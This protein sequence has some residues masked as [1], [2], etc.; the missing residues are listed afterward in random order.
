MIIPMRKNWVNM[1]IDE[2]HH[3]RHYY[4]EKYRRRR[5]GPRFALILLFIMAMLSL[6][7]AFIAMIYF[8]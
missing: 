1:P 5:R 8:T 7:L 2:I 6:I 4:S 3:H